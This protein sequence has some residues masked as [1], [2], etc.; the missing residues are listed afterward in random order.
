MMWDDVL[1][2]MLGKP[3]VL[4]GRDENGVDCLGLIIYAYRRMGFD[5]DSI[6]KQYP[7]HVTF[8]EFFVNFRDAALP[9]S[10]VPGSIVLIRDGNRNPVH[11]C[12]QGEEYTYHPV[13]GSVVQILDTVETRRYYKL[14]CLN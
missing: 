8:K 13:R 6:D 1:K 2:P 3:Y 7:E 9:G 4:N 11:L 5:V 14:K 12:I 10:D